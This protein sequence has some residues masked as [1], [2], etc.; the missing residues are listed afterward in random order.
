MQDT[1]R[2]LPLELEKNGF[3]YHQ[4]ARGERAAIYRQTQGGKK[5]G[6]EVFRLKV[7]N[8]HPKDADQTQKEPFPGNEDFGRW[9]W[10]YNREQD[11]FFKY[12]A[13]EREQVVA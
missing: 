1:I 10:A 4:R 13:L 3:T 8:A 9:A 5:V 2:R 11:A 12:I 6:F 7:V